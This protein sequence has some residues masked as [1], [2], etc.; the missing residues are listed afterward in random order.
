[1]RKEIIPLVKQFADLAELLMI[2][3]ER[4]V[5]QSASVAQMQKATELQAYTLQKAFQSMIFGFDIMKDKD[6]LRM[7]NPNNNN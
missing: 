4:A 6:M 5:N 7:W 1:M 3:T 2:A